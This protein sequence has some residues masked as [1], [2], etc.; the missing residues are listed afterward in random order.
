M[1]EKKKILIIE[2]EPD[3]REGL[4]KVFE[5]EGFE[6]EECDNGD[7]GLAR[8]G[9]G[10]P[11]LVILDLMIPGRDGLEVCRELRARGLTVPVL[12]LTARSG[13]VEKILGFELGADDYVTKPFS[14]LE[15][16]ARVK[17][18]L[19]RAGVETGGPERFEFGDVEVDLKRYKITRA[20]KT[21][22]LYHYEAEILRILVLNEGDVVP[23]SRILDRV[24]GEDSFPTTRTVDFHIC[25]LRKKIEEDAA[26]PRHI[27]TVHG[28]G[29]RFVR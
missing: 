11:H 17:A 1:G 18:L 20:G 29:Y 13:E 5:T 10:N 21:V 14:V 15:L 12:I 27:L 24:W 25:N 9:D 2:D 19:R 23:R 7:A 16:L 26:R 22:E 4:R 8:A 28:V 3:V 6:V